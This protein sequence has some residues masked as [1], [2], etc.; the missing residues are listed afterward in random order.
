MSSRQTQET[1][2]IIWSADS[3]SEFPVSMELAPTTRVSIS[4]GTSLTI[5]RDGLVLGGIWELGADVKLEFST[6]ATQ[7]RS[8]IPGSIMM[9]SGDTQISL[10]GDLSSLHLQG[11]NFHCLG[12]SGSCT[13]FLIETGASVFWD[14]L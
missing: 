7:N 9:E 6:S 4:P 14:G 8:F 13:G 11:D 10:A 5:G 1:N 2:S 12:D 3:S